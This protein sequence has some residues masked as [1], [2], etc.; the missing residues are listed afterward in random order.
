MPD[1]PPIPQKAKI[2]D[3]S[4]ALS[5]VWSDWFQKLFLRVGGHNASTNLELETVTASRIASGA[6]SFVKLLSTDWSSSQATSGYQKLGSGLY[7][8]WGI[9][10][11]LNSATTTSIT[12]P[13]AFPTACFQVVPG[14]RNNSAGTTTDTGHFGT[15]NYSTTAF[16]L[17]NRTSAANTFNWM[18]VGN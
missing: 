6:V 15:G 4:G 9:T 5:R 10:A 11:S 16:D 2:Q 1:L 3:E 13:I 14:I 17:Y 7:I 18:A 8:Q 12:F